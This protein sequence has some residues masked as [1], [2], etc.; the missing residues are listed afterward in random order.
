[1]IFPQNICFL[2]KVK[3]C[4]YVAC[5]MWI[6]SQIRWQIVWNQDI[7]F[8]HF[9]HCILECS[10]MHMPIKC[11][12]V[13]FTIL[14]WSRE[15]T[16][17]AFVSA[18]TLQWVILMWLFYLHKHLG[19]KLIRMLMRDF[20]LAPHMTREAHWTINL[21]INQSINQ[22]IKSRVTLTISHDVLRSSYIW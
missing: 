22:S 7:R 16:F 19:L 2:R 13:R 15:S 11:N 17:Y 12:R 21:S 6:Q 3:S 8:S 14:S 5:V 10:L 1:M 20:S 4:S 9:N 18:F